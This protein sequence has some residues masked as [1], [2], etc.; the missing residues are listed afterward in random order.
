MGTT[1]STTEQSFSLGYGQNWL[2]GK[3][4]STS[5]SAGYSHSTKYALRNL[6]LPDGSVD[7]DY[8]YLEYDQH[9]FNLSF[10]LGHRWTPNFAIL[11]LAGGISGSLIDN[12]YDENLY[13]PYDSTIG[14]Y[15]NNWEPK[16]SIFGSF[17]AD[18][19]DINYDPSSGWFASERL[20]WYGLL[21]E[22]ILPFA[23][24]WGEKEFYLK[25]D[26]KEEK[27]FKLINL[28]FL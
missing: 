11:T 4:I 7:D 23:K 16:N 22:G 8:Y 9:E 5:F 12:I 27:N 15:N 20:A 28:P 25:S 26:T 24:N 3:P 21:P 18:G 6:P 14:Q 1:L 10:S 17:S 13:I 2:F 19:R